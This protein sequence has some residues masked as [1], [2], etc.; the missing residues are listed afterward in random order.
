VIDLHGVL[1][2]VP[3]VALASITV[4]LEAGIHALLGGKADG[5]SIVLGVLA[6]RVRLRG[7]S[8][9][10]LGS[11]SGDA[12]VRRAVAYVPLDVA[13]PE[14]L[15]V[16][17]TLA[18]AAC[19]RGEAAADPC[20][21]LERFGIGALAARKVS[22]LSRDEARAVAFVE[23]LTSN[24]QVLLLEE[25]LA[26]LDARAVG[27]VAEA[28]RERARA[29]ACIVIVTGSI[30]D[31]RTLADD[32]LTF[33]RGTMVRR[34]VASDP[35][36][37]AGPRGARVRILASDAKRLA[38]ALAT[39]D[40]VRAV[41]VEG[42]V[43]IADGADVIGV[44]TAVAR[45]ALREDISIELLRPDLLRQDELRAAISGDTAGAYRAAYERALGSARAPATHLEPSPGAS[46][47]ERDVG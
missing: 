9:R 39:E 15:R 26:S 2:R 37:I 33:D 14:P 43:L 4:R 22:S 5:P 30:R 25:P 31:A 42:A 20:G 1:A 19:I 40:V 11:A 18:I 21:R 10:V 24:A 46:P 45:A 27:P 16:D 35:L 32:I 3:P 41:T 29:G 8:A 13:L 47:A 34:A 44:V 38:I 6:G 17:E 7:G 23:A 36:V 12:H 28:L